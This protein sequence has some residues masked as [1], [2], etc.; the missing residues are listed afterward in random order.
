MTQRLI[1]SITSDEEWPRFDGALASQGVDPLA[2]PIDRFLSLA[3]WH[4]VK[5]VDRFSSEGQ[6][7]LRKFEARLWMPPAGV[8]VTEGPW[9]AAAE[10][11]SFQAFKKMIKPDDPMNPAAGA[12][13]AG[14][15]QQRPSTADRPQRRPAPE[16]ARQQQPRRTAP[17]VAGRHPRTSGGISSAVQARG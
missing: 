13:A 2:L 4:L 6:Q 14:K 10:T 16:P 3:Y 17:A 9:S 12:V 11:A 1:A 8:E 5:D 7:A 15:P